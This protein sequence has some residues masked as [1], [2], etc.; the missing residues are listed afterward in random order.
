[1]V[2]KRY[3]HQYGEYLSDVDDAHYRVEYYYLDMPDDIADAAE[4]H[5]TNMYEEV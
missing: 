3:F 1:M 5:F 2:T 4:V